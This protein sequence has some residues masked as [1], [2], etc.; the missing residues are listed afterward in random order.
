MKKSS[1]DYSEDRLMV[2]LILAIIISLVT[3]WTLV[4]S[5]DFNVFEGRSVSQDVAIEQSYSSINVGVIGLTIF[6]HDAN[7]TGVVG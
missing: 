6:P 2:F 7:E 4:L 5:L 1:E 3:V